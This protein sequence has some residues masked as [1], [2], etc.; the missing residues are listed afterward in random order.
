MSKYMIIDGNR[1][2]FDKE[3]NILDVVRKSGI[4]L[5]T[6]CYYSELSI[7]GACRMCVVEDERG[8]IIASCST[9]PKDKMSIKTNTPKINQH[10]KMI[11]ELLLA[12]HCRDCTICEKNG[13]CKLQELALRFG[14]KKIRFKDTHK[15]QK[16]DTSS[17]AIIRDPNKCILCGDCV[18]V[19]NEVQNVGAIDFAY[20]GPKMEVSP[21]FERKLSE[22]DC[23][24]CGQCAAV[25]P[26]G[27]IIVRSDA[28]SVW[29]AIYNK[30][31]RV[32]VQIAPAVRVALGEEFGIKHGENVMN[33]IVAA[34]RRIGFDEIYDTSLTADTTIIEE[35]KEFLEKLESGDNSYPLFTS[36]CPAWVRYV[37]TKHP[38]LMK[39][40][41]S[42]KS[43]MQMFGSIVKEYFKERDEKEG[44]ETISVAV[45]PC[46]AKKSEA[47]REEFVRN[48]IRDIDYVITTTELCRMIT[49]LG[50]KFDEIEAE[51]PD[52][53]FSVH[54]GAGVIF[55]TTG[56]VTEAVIRGV[57]EDKSM[58]AL[59]NIEF[60][61]VRG[62]D[63]I[64]ALE[65]P[66]GDKT[67]RIGVVS[68]L[69][70]AEQL[71]ERI[72]SGEEHFDFV[73]VM[74]CPGGCIAGAGQPFSFSKVKEER[75]KG[76]YK[77]DKV[78]EIKR[79]QENP[80]IT[81]LYNG[82]LKDRSHELLHVHYGKCNK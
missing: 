2:E 79:S 52:M 80:M 81:S 32:V 3:K 41:S 38:E 56:G 4:D 76:L 24:S 13:K 70:N 71:I 36:C 39:Y 66:M 34:M 68:G 67:L 23:V 64:K 11:L 9:P 33:K 35:T 54:S 60:I 17:R 8:G 61:G 74:A 10:R 43:P 30:K 14:V 53:P 45:M 73:E 25:C 42:C 15:L 31:Q 62:M 75:M 77:D 72:E 7:Y 69:N 51:A 12:S 20:R 55:G 21:A 47:A 58:K 19:C 48:G 16:L 37:E 26:T 46:T 1:V 28:A 50:I 22:T 78:T 63:G 44:K 6:F 5:P 59:K 29:E 57:V 82:L 27:A 40:V 65:L 49:E 18:R